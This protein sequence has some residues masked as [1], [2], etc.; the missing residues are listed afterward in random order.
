MPRKLWRLVYPGS[1]GSMFTTERA[2]Y[3]A[4]DRLRN[5]WVAGGST[6]SLTV[7]VDDCDGH[8]WWTWEHIDFAT[9]EAA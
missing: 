2:A 4:V 9:E 3:D 6:G 8:G 1:P 7:Q 5:A